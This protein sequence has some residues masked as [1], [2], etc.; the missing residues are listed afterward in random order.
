MIYYCIL[1]K[2][3]LPVPVFLHFRGR[4]ILY[5]LVSTRHPPNSLSQNWSPPSLSV[6]TEHLGTTHNISERYCLV[7]HSIIYTELSNILGDRPWI[8]KT[9][10]TGA[11]YV[12]PF[13]PYIDIT[14]TSGSILLLPEPSMSKIKQ[15][16]DFKSC[17]FVSPPIPFISWSMCL[18]YPVLAESKDLVP[19]FR[20][21]LKTVPFL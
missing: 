12:S 19:M 20:F 2:E 18:L 1:H 4:N 8:I 14:E 16:I 5:L 17:K 11:S 9:K 13:L 7:F 10:Y 21:Y 15:Q 6:N 3:Y